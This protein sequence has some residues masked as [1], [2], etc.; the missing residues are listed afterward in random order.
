MKE[1]LVYASQ[2]GFTERYAQWIGQALG[3]TAIP[4]KACRRDMVAE[5]DLVIFGGSVR[6]SIIS[7]QSKLERML[8]NAG[9]TAVIEF[10]VGIRPETPRTLE[11]V[12]KNNLSQEAWQRPFYYFQGGMERAKLAPGD[13]TLLRVYQSMAN[14]RKDGNPED[15][16][17]MALLWRDGDYT[18]QEKILPLVEQVRSIQRQ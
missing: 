15:R 7:G 1:L 4:L 10:A 2:T 11:L 13:R 9:Q 5:A 16:E 3:I 17:A 8:K 6:G 12:K 14:R 18:S